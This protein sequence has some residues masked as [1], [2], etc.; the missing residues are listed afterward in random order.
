[1]GIFGTDDGEGGTLA[2]RIALIGILCFAFAW[3][4]IF[5]AWK[6]FSVFRERNRSPE[7]EV[8]AGNMPVTT[9]PAKPDRISMQPEKPP[10][11]TH[12]E[13]RGKPRK[14][15]PTQPV[16]PMM[17]MLPDTQA[18][19]YDAL[20]GREKT[21]RVYNSDETRSRLCGE[22]VTKGHLGDIPCLME[23]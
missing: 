21:T 9:N 2:E 4:P 15:M 11:Q 5:I 20:K 18:I 7:Q 1:M 8:E 3:I 22:K 6:V 12:R 10:A 13:C 16:E 19:I 17:R 23:V 14:P